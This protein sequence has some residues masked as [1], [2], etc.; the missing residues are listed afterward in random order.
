MLHHTT[1]YILWILAIFLVACTPGGQNSPDNPTKPSPMQKSPKRGVSFD[2]KKID[3]LPLLSP[4]I[5]WSYN[6]GNDQNASAALWFDTNEMD[7]CPMCWNNSYSADKIREYVKEHPNTKYLLGF[8]EPNLTDQCNMTPS[9]AAQYWPQ[10]VALA[11]ELNLSLV[12]PAMNYGTLAGYHDPV[13]WLDEFFA[14]PER[15]KTMLLEGVDAVMTDVKDACIGVSTAD[16]VPIIIYDSEHHAACVVHAG[17]RG[18]VQLIG[19][20]T[21]DKMV[22]EFGCDPKDIIAGIGPNIGQ[23]CY[24]V[25]D[26][27]INEFKKHVRCFRF[28]NSFV[29]IFELWHCS[30]SITITFVGLRISGWKNFFIFQRFHVEIQKSR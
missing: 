20:C 10:V 21:V 2:F 8:N 25:D 16:C 29:F 6:W 12:S 24:E 14:L 5:S 17:W 1:R 11:K 18:T 22:K 13:K 19:K 15:I 28:F 27:V 4:A 30:V 7:F 3:D 26:P 23:C 9:Q